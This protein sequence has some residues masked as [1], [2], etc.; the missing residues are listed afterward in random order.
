MPK[1][2][3]KAS[4]VW[5]GGLIDGSGTMSL[6]SSGS[7]TDMPVSWASRTEDSGGKTSP[8]ELIAGAH[9]SCYAMAFSNTL[10]QAGHA[11]EQLSVDAVCVFDV[12]EGGA[13]VTRSDLTVTGKVPGLDQAGF[14]ELARQGEQGCPVS[15]ALRNNVEITV[16]A[17]LSS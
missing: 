16:T 8:E 4:V 9:A 7:A 10:V 17:T 11:P 2:E 13:K 1:A 6:V 15:N 12:G 14:E 5:N 3:R